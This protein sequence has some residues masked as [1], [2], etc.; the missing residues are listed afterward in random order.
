MRR[1][2]SLRQHF[3]TRPIKLIVKLN[4]SLTNES[5]DINSCLHEHLKV[6]RS[7][8]KRRRD[9]SEVGGYSPLNSRMGHLCVNHKSRYT[10]VTQIRGHREI[11]I[12]DDP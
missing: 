4:E 10:E 9:S 7:W 1:S 6:S 3:V 5:G 8:R 2:H 11:Q 12:S